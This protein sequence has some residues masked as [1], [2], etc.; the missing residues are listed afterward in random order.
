[1]RT[2]PKKSPVILLDVADDTVGQSLPAINHG[3]MSV[4]E[5]VQS[6]AKR[7]DPE[8]ALLVKAQ[9]FDEITG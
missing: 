5:P 6:A 8:R 7:P 1:M 4:F 2:H 9:A 3:E